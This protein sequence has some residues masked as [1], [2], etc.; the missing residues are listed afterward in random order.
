M[1]SRVSAWR[2]VPWS[3]DWVHVFVDVCV[4][5]WVSVRQSVLVCPFQHANIDKARRVHLHNSRDTYT[6]HKTAPISR[7][8]DDLRRNHNLLVSN[9]FI[10]EPMKQAS[11]ACVAMCACSVST[12]E[13]SP[14][15]ERARTAKP[16]I[17]DRME[18]VSETSVFVVQLRT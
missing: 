6:D 1:A 15:G 7:D 4:R 12:M 3:D 13:A 5:V 2:A 14:L 9:A 11:L 17:A 8:S 10:Y 18:S 16:R